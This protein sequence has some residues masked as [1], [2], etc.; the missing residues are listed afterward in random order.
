MKTFSSRYPPSLM[1]YGATASRTAAVTASSPALSIALTARRVDLSAR[2]RVS[3]SGNDHTHSTSRRSPAVNPPRAAN[4]SSAPDSESANG[5]T[6]PAGGGGSSGASALT[7]AAT[8]LLGASPQV[9]TTIG[10]PGRLT[11]AA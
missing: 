11:R 10:A 8:S 5:P 3:S 2:S 1:P 9:A 7:Y 6:A 4:P